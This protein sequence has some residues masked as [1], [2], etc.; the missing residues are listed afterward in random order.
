MKMN[1]SFKL[2]INQ[3]WYSF[4]IFFPPKFIKLN[5]RYWPNFRILAS[6]LSFF[7]DTSLFLHFLPIFL[8]FLDAIT[9][10]NV[11]LTSHL[12]GQHVR[13][14]LRLRLNRSQTP[15]SIRSTSRDQSYSEHYNLF[16][17]LRRPCFTRA[18]YSFE[19]KVVLAWISTTA[20]EPFK[21]TEGC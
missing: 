7:S 3:T 16:L 1:Y 17:W 15:Y 19:F 5:S 20:W 8:F 10:F 4:P 12:I 6:L 21:P 13:K 11:F 9:R 2:E 18:L 14:H